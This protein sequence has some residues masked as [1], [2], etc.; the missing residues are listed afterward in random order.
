MKSKK[1]NLSL[2]ILWGVVAYAI[3]L[4]TYCTMNNFLNSSA[5]DISAFGSILG[6]CGAFFAAFVAT[7]LFNDWKVQ[8]TFNRTQRFHDECIDVILKTT[9]KLSR[10]ET[11][12]EINRVRFMEGQLTEEQINK[13]E[14]EFNSIVKE[15]IIY[16]QD[17]THDIGV[18]IALDYSKII[19][20]NDEELHFVFNTVLEIKVF[21]QQ[22]ARDKGINKNNILKI[23]NFISNLN[24]KIDEKLQNRNKQK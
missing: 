12:I 18:K 5:D 19:K 21:V 20:N 15:T 10:L 2:V 8:E 7:Y 11:E 23:Q 1:V 13:I 9:K 22:I 3:A 17:L 4:L 16:V 6:A 24:Q 14:I